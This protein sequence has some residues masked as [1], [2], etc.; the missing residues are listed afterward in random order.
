L[1]GFFCQSLAPPPVAPAAEYHIAASAAELRARCVAVAENEVEAWINAP[2]LPM[3]DE[4]MKPTDPLS[5]WKDNQV[6]FP[7][8]TRL[9]RRV[10]CVPATSAA[11]ERLFSTAGLIITK[12]R[13][14]L[15]SETA[16]LLI[17][18]RNAWPV[19]DAWKE[20]KNK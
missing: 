2:Y 19:V 1:G 7:Y 15:S 11:S 13:N 9:V 3:F 16:A 10:L 4:N 12:K 14:R 20:K 5:Y 17:Y 6:K 18:L 8:M